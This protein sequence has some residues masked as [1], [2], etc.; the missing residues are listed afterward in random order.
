[1]PTADLS[2]RGHKNSSRYSQGK[3]NQNCKLREDHDLFYFMQMINVCHRRISIRGA[4]IMINASVDQKF[5]RW[6]ADL[7]SWSLSNRATT[8][9]H[10]KNI[11]SWEHF[12]S[13][14]YLI[15]IWYMYVLVYISKKAKFFVPILLQF[16]P[17]PYLWNA[18]TTSC[19][20][21]HLHISSERGTS[22]TKCVVIALL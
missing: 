10:I 14:V 22:Y 8:R 11:N 12:C 19:S 20:P 1:M 17:C 2:G 9:I 16:L 13:V 21:R 15:I 6:S 4:I 5:E 7:P 3:Q 18:A